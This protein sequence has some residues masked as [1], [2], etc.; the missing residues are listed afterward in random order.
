MKVDKF[1]IIMK[2]LL[3]LCIFLIGFASSVFA[4]MFFDVSF[5]LNGSVF[6]IRNS[7]NESPADFVKERDILVYPDRVV[8]KIPGASIGRYAAT[9]SMKPVLDE[10][11]NGIRIRPGNEDEI[12]VGDI[13]TFRN[14]G[15]LIIHRVIEKGHDKEGI[16]FVTQ[17]DS[18]NVTDGKIRFSEIVYKTVGLIY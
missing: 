2:I 12:D 16:F 8:I 7:N 11:T 4:S 15:I 3:V 9:G 5:A 10:R 6:G 14:D 17:G 18:N 13:I 1:E